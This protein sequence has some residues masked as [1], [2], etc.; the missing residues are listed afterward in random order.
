MKF[1]SIFVWALALFSLVALA[2][3]SSSQSTNAA[4]SDAGKH[5]IPLT[6]TS[7]DFESTL[8]PWTKGT[9]NCPES[10]GLARSNR[11]GTNFCP[12]PGSWSAVLTE[13]I[14]STPCTNDPTAVWQEASYT[15][16]TAG[17]ASVTWLAKNFSSGNPPYC[18]TCD[19]IAYI[20][21]SP[22]TT[23][24]QFT[25]LGPA[26]SILYYE[27]DVTPATCVQEPCYV[28]VAIGFDSSQ[29]GTQ[30]LYHDCVDVDIP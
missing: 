2:V 27:A 24:S 26:T 15:L 3:A 21:T 12:N 8:S 4:S 13:T 6:L 19:A 18:N 7:Y 22:P 10:S 16:S 17:T 25:D 11:S 20:G 9:Y 28:Y 5:A 1:R 23:L 29:Q 30:T 14:G